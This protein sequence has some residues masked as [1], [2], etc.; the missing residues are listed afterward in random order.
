MRTEPIPMTQRALMN[1]A[2]RH[3]IVAPG[4]IGLVIASGAGM[5]ALSLVSLLK[6]GGDARVLG[7]ATALAILTVMVGRMSLRLPLTRCV[8]SVSDALLFLGVLLF[9][10]DV[11]TLMGA[12]DGY[13]ASRRA[14]GGM[15]KRLF[16]TAGMALSVG[17][18]ARLYGLAVHSQKLSPTPGGLV[19]GVVLLV[20]AQYAINTLLV[21]TAM[22]LAEGASP[23]AVLRGSFAWAGACY[24]AGG[25]VAA[26]VFE[27]SRRAGVESAT[28]AVM[29][30]PFLFHAIC[31]AALQK[32]VSLQRSPV[33]G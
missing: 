23:V 11:A 7:W 27:A 28:L 6:T 21:V 2:Q 4:F 25:L 20:A 17:I 8:V 32:R 22:T 15:H 18:S 5:L 10:A 3:D 9:G 16:N 33:R 14:R 1:G 30:V 24:L 13:A 31:R 19:V 12:L 26:V 29:P